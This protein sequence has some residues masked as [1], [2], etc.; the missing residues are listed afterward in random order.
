MSGSPVWVLLEERN[1]FDWEGQKSGIKKEGIWSGMEMCLMTANS[2]FGCTWEDIDPL[3][4]PWISQRRQ[5][6]QCAASSDIDF[7]KTKSKKYSKNNKQRK[8]I[9]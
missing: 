4:Q 2:S 6:G 7:K 5:Q 8:Q 9:M 3:G 1:A